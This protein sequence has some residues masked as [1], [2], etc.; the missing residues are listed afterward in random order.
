MDVNSKNTSVNN[1]NLGSHISCIYRTDKELFSL[2]I[3][4]FIDGLLKN[5]KCI[6][7]PGEQSS[8]EIINAFKEFGFDISPHILAKDFIITSYKDI[9]LKNDVFD[10]SNTTSNLVNAESNALKQE[11]SALRYAGS[12]SWITEN[13]LIIPEFIKYE[14]LVNDFIESSFIIAACLYKEP[15]FKEEVLTNI[16]YN[17]PLVYLYDKLIDNSYYSPLLNQQD[18]ALNELNYKEITNNLYQLG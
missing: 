16:I 15:L 4:F 14:R 3:P 12:A 5:N 8:E 13:T 17:H 6:F 9:Y 11:Y 7:I 10:I 1:F 2:V 18:V